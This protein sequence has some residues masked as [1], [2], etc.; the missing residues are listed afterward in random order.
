MIRVAI[1]YICTG[2][3]DVF[4]K[5]FFESYEQNFLNKCIKEY[6]VFTDASKIYG[7][8][9]CDRI[10]KIYQK[11]LGWPYD[12][13]MRYNMFYSIKNSLEQFDYIFFMNANC[14]CVDKI[15][16]EVFL[17]KEK[18]ILVVQHPGAYNKKTKQFTYDRNPN[19]TAFIP[20]GKGEYYVCGGI[21][22]GKAKAY[23]DLI[24]ELKDN[25]DIDLN[26]GIIAKWHDESHINHYIF[27]HNNWVMLS[28][29]YS[30]AEG[31][32]LPFEPK[33]M[34]RE[35]SRYFDPVMMKRGK[36]ASIRKKTIDKVFNFVRG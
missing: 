14:L 16:E 19:S 13:L 5:D 32:K 25:I 15:T 24:K 27:T 1:L 22:G 9:V 29:S 23:I 18:D 4:W 20:K 30:Y 8:D 17:P 3:Y 2:Q 21:N 6:F 31:W 28:P 11:Q 36:L 26:N 34:L 33:I 35:K 12:T 7:E 10:H